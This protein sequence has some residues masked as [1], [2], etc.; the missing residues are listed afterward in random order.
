MELKE[1]YRGEI[2]YQEEE[3]KEGLV[4][5]IILSAAEENIR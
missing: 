3:Q 1:R 4:L 2:T 5:E